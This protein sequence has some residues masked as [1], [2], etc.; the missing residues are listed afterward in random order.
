MPEITS[1]EI[2]KVIGQPIDTSLAVPFEITEIAD[3]EFAEFGEDVYYF[4]AA[5]DNTDTVYT[6]AD[7]GEVTSN[8]KSP[9]GATS[10]TFVGLQSDL[11]YV[12][13]NELS[14]A[15]DQT[16][17]ARKKVA[18]T[19]SM[20]KIEVKRLLDVILAISAQE[21][22]LDSGED[23][24]DGILKMVHKV[25]DF[26]TDFAL[27][28]GS[29]VWEAINKFDKDNADNF[30]YRI[31]IKDMLKENGITLVKVVGQ[32]K[33]DSGSYDSVLSATKA[34]L[35]ARNSNLKVGKPCLFVRRRINPE[36]AGQ[37][38]IAPDAAQRLVTTIGGLQVI[39]NH[40]NI[41]GYGCIGY[42]SVIEAVTLSKAV[43]WSDELAS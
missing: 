21:V 24:Y 31:S 30:N 34:I 5:D 36:V 6:A 15:K 35:V 22:E 20:D 11:A 28:V 40:K 32:V 10:L 16:A 9:S 43:C 8:K 4:A 18:I 19:R 42:E 26:G 33:V 1:L 41:L 27:L 2:A 39:N 29:T 23:L 3:I 14:D 7:S 25:I 37:L 17:L 38:G 13:I 12:T